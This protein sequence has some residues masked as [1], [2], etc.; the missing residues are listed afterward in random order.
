M[1]RDQYQKKFNLHHSKIE[2]RLNWA[3]EVVLVKHPPQE[4]I[5]KIHASQI[6][7]KKKWDSL[8]R[9]ES[10]AALVKLMEKLV[11]EKVELTKKAVEIESV[12]WENKRMT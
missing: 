11:E 8:V 7:L 9:A 5:P 6:D 2:Q 10:V 4:N 12:Y 1:N 3:S